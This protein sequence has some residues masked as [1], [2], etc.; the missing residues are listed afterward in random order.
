M[1]NI[2]QGET[3]R[4]SIMAY[5]HHHYEPDSGTKLIRMQQRV[6]AYQIIG[7]GLYKTSVT[8]PLL[9]CLSRDEGKELL[10]QTHSG[11]CEGHIGARA[12][13][14]KV[15]RQGFYWPSIINDVLKLVTTCQACQKL[16][17]NTRA[18]SKPSQLI[19]S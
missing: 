12:L 15:F 16:L 8:G 3:W 19:T 17:P 1:I 10:A 14:A 18:P 9:H 5:L 13:T 4:A 2:I 7:D 6:K 11:V